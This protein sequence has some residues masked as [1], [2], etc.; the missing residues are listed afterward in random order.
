MSTLKHVVVAPTTD[1]GAISCLFENLNL[2]NTNRDKIW[3]TPEFSNIQIP[4]LYVGGLYVGMYK[5]RLGD[6]LKLWSDTQWHDGNRYYYN[7]I[8]TPLSG[9]NTTHWYN[10]DT[11]TFESGRYNN[12][13]LQFMGLARPAF[14]QIR[15]SKLNNPNAAISKLTIFDLVRQL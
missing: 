2:I 14:D 12:G 15:N 9:M 13:R 11:K 8:G 4:G 3:G 5:I 7:I 6:I 10:A 1:K